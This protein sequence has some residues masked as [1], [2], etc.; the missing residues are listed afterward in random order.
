ML[1]LAQTSLQNKLVLES[2][3]KGSVVVTGQSVLSHTLHEIQLN[4]T[5]GNVLSFVNKLIAK[6]KM[7]SKG[8]ES[9]FVS[10]G[11][12]QYISNKLKKK[13]ESDKN[14][15]QRLQALYLKDSKVHLSVSETEKNQVSMFDCMPVSILKLYMSS[16]ILEISSK[17]NGMIA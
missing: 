2:K 14:L 17:S 4:A 11:L 16:V 8:T 5:I 10:G 9:Q 13:D 12:Q 3:S 15:T 7:H 1:D 6:Y